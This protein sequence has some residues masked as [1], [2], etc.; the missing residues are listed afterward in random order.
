[1]HL[2]PQKLKADALDQ[3]NSQIKELFED[4][5]QDVEVTVAGGNVNGVGGR[6]HS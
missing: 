4:F 1:M 3:I 2:V 5:I 6:S